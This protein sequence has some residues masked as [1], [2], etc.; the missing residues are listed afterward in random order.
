MVDLTLHPKSSTFA[1]AMATSFVRSD[2]IER[3]D[4]SQPFFDRQLSDVVSSTID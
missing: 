2:F 3:E 1:T 4:A